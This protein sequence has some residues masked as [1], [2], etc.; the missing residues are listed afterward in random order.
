MVGGS[1]SCCS[2]KQ[3]RILTPRTARTVKFIMEYGLLSNND[4]PSCIHV[5]PTKYNYHYRGNI[6]KRQKRNKKKNCGLCRTFAR[7]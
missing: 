6:N 5:V 7:D 3:I 1:H 4:Y 2:V